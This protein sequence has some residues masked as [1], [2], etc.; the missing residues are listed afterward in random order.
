MKTTIIGMLL[1]FM[2]FGYGVVVS[3]AQTKKG[4]VVVNKVKLSDEILLAIKNTY[5]SGIPDGNY[6]YDSV[7]GAWGME[8]GPTQ[9]FTQAGLELGGPLRADASNGQTKVFINGR[10]LHLYDVLRL[11]QLVNPYPVLPGRYWV[12][13]QGNFG[14]EGGWAL[15]NLVQIAQ[16]KNGSNGGPILSDGNGCLGFIEGGYSAISSNC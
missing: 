6:W 16:A 7:S 3:N 11:Q 13:S 5:G 14:Y 12:D 4:N 9:G 1:T 10:E 8:G 2:F 15:G